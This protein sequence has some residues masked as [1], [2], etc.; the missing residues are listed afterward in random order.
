LNRPTY[1][2]GKTIAIMLLLGLLTLGPPL[3]LLI[4]L[5]L[6]D[7]GP[8]T[9]QEWMGEFVAIAAAGVMMSAFYTAVSMAVSAATDR[10]GAA[11]ATT[12]GVLVGSTAVANSV[13]EAADQ[14]QLFRLLSLQE[15]PLELA[16]RIHGE[17]GSWSRFDLSDTE[18]WVGAVGITAVC[19]AWIW[20]AYRRMLVRR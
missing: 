10:K 9:V 18:L 16:F 20:F 5:T 6:A 13:V 8:D 19:A 7:S 1:L 12:I 3:M 4:A 11:V 2:I 15:L 17:V 14:S